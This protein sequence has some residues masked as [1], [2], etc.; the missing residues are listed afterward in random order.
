ME[1]SIVEAK[2]QLSYLIRAV[3]E[4]EPVIITRSGRPVAQIVP[5]P[6]STRPVQFDGMRDRIKFLPGWDDPIDLDRFLK[7]DL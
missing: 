5:P 1:V 2:N 3:E 6:A 7:G 4:G